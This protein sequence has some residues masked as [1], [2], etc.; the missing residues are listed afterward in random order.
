MPSGNLELNTSRLEETNEA[1]NDGKAMHPKGFLDGFQTQRKIRVTYDRVTDAL[2]GAIGEIPLGITLPRN[3][4]IK[5]GWIAVVIAPTAAGSATLALKLVG[6]ND[7]L[8]AL[9]KAS[10]INQIDC[11][12]DGAAAN[13]LKLS[14]PKELILTVAVSPLDTGKFHVYLEYDISDPA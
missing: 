11:V 9:A 1:A 7:V 2:E 4:V 6:A 13:M 3:A 14:D 10:F 8:S 12:E 5:K